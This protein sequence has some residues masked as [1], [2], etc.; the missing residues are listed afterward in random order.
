MKKKFFVGIVITLILS[1][2]G[3]SVYYFIT[4]ED[5]VTTLNL[6]EKQ[7]IENNKNNKI[8]IS[9]LSNVPVLANGGEGIIIDF[10]DKLNE[11]TNL[12]FNKVSYNVLDDIKTSYSL[13]LVSE[14]ND[15]RIN[16]Y[17]DNYVL[18]SK[19]KVYTN[20][21]NLEI[22]IGVLN[23]DLQQ[24]NNYLNS[25]FVTY[26]TYDSKE[27]M[28]N[29][30]E[31]NEVDCVV[32]L[33]TTNLDDILLNNY[34][35]AYN[36][37]DYKKYYVLE[38]G[39]NDTLNNILTK[40]FKKWYDG[41]YTDSYNKH[42]ARNYFKYKE[43][44]DSDAVR[45]RSKR[46]NYGFIKN[47]PYDTI[48]SNHFAGINNSLIK[49]FTSLTDA[50]VNY[51]SYDNVDELVKSFNKNEID[52]FYGINLQAKY[53]MDVYT[54]SEAYDNNL[55]I[56]KHINNTDIINNV[57]S[58]KN[59]SIIKDT[60]IEDY[61]KKN[62]VTY[63][64][65]D[66]LD[67][68]VSSIKDKDVIIMDLNNYNH[69]KKQLDK[70]IV[71]NIFNLDGLSFIIRDISDN[72]VFSQI[73]DFYITFNDSSLYI[74]DGL[75]ETLSVSKTPI[76]LKKVAIVLGSV[77]VILLTI[78][79]IIKIKPKKKSSNLS[80]EDKLRYIDSLTSLK[81]RNYLNDNVA[82]W[83]S[84]E[85]YP[86]CVMIVDLNNIAYINDNYGHTE[87]D[88]TISEA[89]NVL[90]VSQLENTEIIRT[91][92]NEFLIYLVGYDEKQIIIYKKKLIKELKE[93]KHN[94]GAAIGYSMITDAIKT[95][96]DA[97]NEATID[98]RENKEENKE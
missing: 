77:V 24:V 92:G 86:Q 40:Y 15:K 17:T 79:S 47:A 73:F 19:D 93:I 68:L 45:F 11:V 31:S 48:I 34:K 62:N 16:V 33:K 35:I 21:S 43:I 39:D 91:N 53:E 65:Y 87:G 26:K 55:V 58:L 52:F 96:D 94:F 18:V 76:L 80:K 82:K 12:N 64:T 38:L 98:M 71:C 97:I 44:T 8:D 70:Y 49:G 7:W 74:T 5:K 54:T 51:K 1:I 28:L 29:A 66:N 42:L 83:D 6:I 89:A 88:L 60:Y 9:I 72:K 81:N 14:L 23:D 85:V 50:E 57:K 41:Y 46:Y 20:L 4:R 90:I 56:L 37:S 69:Y 13:K 75:N 84:S 61:L 27:L 25:S 2:L 30:L 78:L 22:N 32:L 95:I 36:I 67:I 10:F 59:V 63:K 3:F